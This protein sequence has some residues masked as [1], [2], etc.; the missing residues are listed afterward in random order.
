MRSKWL[1]VS[2]VATVVMLVSATSVFANHS[3]SKYHWEIA[4]AP[5]SLDIGD[6]LADGPWNG[7]LDTANANWNDLTPVLNNSVVQGAAASVECVAATGAVEVCASDYGNTGWLG[8]AGISIKRGKD[9][10]ITRGYVKLNDFYYDA[11]APGTG[12][13]TA[14]HRLFVVCQEI[15]HVFGLDHQDED[16]NNANLDTCMDYTGTMTTAQTTPN[17][18]DAEQ[19]E[20]IYAHVHGG[21]KVKGGGGGGKGGGKGKPSGQGAVSSEWGRAIHADPTG[22][23]DVFARQSANGDLEITHVTW[24]Y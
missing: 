5:L 16:F 8:I 22:R 7:F 9:G 20:A 15:G 6:N 13:N 24:A 3:W 10:H 14:D 11:T 4:E 23:A 12:Y 2:V 19:L 18:H 1:M 17:A 21:D